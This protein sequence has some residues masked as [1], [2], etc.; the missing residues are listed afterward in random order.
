MGCKRKKLGVNLDPSFPNSH[1]LQCWRILV[2]I[3]LG[4]DCLVNK[5]LKGIRVTQ[6]QR[7]YALKWTKRE[8]KQLKHCSSYKIVNHSKNKHSNNQENTNQ[9][10][11]PLNY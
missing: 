2:Y 10:M 7:V 5:K 1:L 8:R 11:Y 9:K 3:I 6:E 4:K